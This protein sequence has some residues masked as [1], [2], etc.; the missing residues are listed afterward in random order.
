MH[1]YHLFW[2]RYVT[3]VLQIP[4]ICV[5]PPMLGYLPVYD[6]VLQDKRSEEIA[7]K[8]HD[9]Y[10]GEVNLETVMTNYEDCTLVFCSRY[11]QPD[12]EK[13]PKDQG[14]HFVGPQISMRKQI[15]PEHEVYRRV[16]SFLSQPPKNPDTPNHVV[17]MSMGSLYRPKDT[18]V[19]PFLEGIRDIP[20]VFL[21]M[22][23]G[24]MEG[25]EEFAESHQ[26]ANVMFVNWAPQLYLLEKA[27]IFVTHAGM[28]S[29]V[30]S[31]C[32]GCPMLLV[33]KFAD[34]PTNAARVEELGAGIR[35]SNEESRQS[36]FIRKTTE[37][38]LL[39]PKYRENCQK[40]GLSL[41]HYSLSPEEL[42]SLPL[43]LPS[44]SEL[45]GGGKEGA[46][47]VEEFVRGRLSKEK[48][49]VGLM[50]RE[51]VGGHLV[52][53]GTPTDFRKASIDELIKTPEGHRSSCC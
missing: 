10:G 28:N 29:V 20:G 46:R 9:L 6:L 44:P 45:G 34:Q 2:V 18:F 8:L 7:K 33:P 15:D 51:V 31:C 35:L 5:S 48:G 40:I 12:S 27:S 42:L 25:W 1:D 47:V 17:F 49:L 24:R 13:Y 22:N 52:L 50:T 11:L 36:E 19:L 39:S 23:I 38:I 21:V 41:L 37:T 26:Y 4:A 53:A 43:S 16:E 30:E 14:F 32:F 3:E